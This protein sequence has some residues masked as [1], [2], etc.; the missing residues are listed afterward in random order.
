GWFDVV[1]HIASA[2]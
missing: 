1:K 2:V